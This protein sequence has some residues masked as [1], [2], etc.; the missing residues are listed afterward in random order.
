MLYALCGSVLLSVI[1]LWSG[2]YY[3]QIYNTSKEVKETAFY[4]LVVFALVSPVKVQNMVLGGG[5]L[6][7][8]GK[9]IYYVD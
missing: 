6:R 8:G 9:K 1:L 7:S 5:I 2:K 3:V 4:I